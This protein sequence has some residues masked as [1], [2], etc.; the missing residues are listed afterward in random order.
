MTDLS[1]DIGGLEARMVEH[2]KRFDRLEDAVT[3]G[4]REVND[5]LDGLK[6]AENQR[7]GAARLGKFLFGGGVVVA[8]LEALR[9]WW[10]K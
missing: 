1:R 5:K 8:I 3:T 10:T 4:F 6:A 9:A 2:D 7:K